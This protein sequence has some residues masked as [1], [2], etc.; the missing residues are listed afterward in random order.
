[1]VPSVDPSATANTLTAVSARTASDAWAV[2]FYTGPNEHDGRIMLTERWDGSRWRQ[3]A[4]PN[5]QF[6]DEKLLAVSA[7]GANEAWAVGSTNK[8]GFASTNPIAAHWDGSAW[9]IVPTPATSGSARSI[10]AGVVDFGTSNAWAV[11]RSRNGRVLVEHWDGSAWSL[12][13]VPDPAVPAGS[14]LASSTL[15]GVAATSPT[16][17]WA[18]GSYAVSGTA[19]TGKTLTMHYDGTA[20]TVVPSPSPSGGT[21]LNPLRTVLNSVTAISPTDVWAVGNTFTTDGTNLP[22]KVVSMHWN[23]TAWR[24][25]S[26]ANPGT[27]AVLTGVSARS[28]TD[29][30]AVGYHDDRS[31]SIPIRVTVTEHWTGS[32]WT[33]VPSPNGTSGDTSLFGV[34]VTPGTGPVWAVGALPTT[35]FILRT[36]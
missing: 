24:L 15:T 9:T 23:G 22:D 14:T 34:S 35:T 10:L 31:G 20:W 17:I 27:N 30:W 8:T 13:A 36:P 7:S 4:T 21:T 16:D 26:T 25:V 29:V 3:V 12:V 28:A 2:G 1:V 18:V 11:G 33:V 19:L 5:V 6:F 32:S